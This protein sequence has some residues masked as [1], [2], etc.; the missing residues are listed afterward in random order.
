V[1]PASAGDAPPFL[2]VGKSYSIIYGEDYQFTVLEIGK[3]GWV[4]VVMRQKNQTALD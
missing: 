2:Q 4:R 1:K 3:E